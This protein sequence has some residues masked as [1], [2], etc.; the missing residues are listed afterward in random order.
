MCGSEEQLFKAKIEGTEMNVCSECSKFGE[1]ITI[2]K[3]EHKK[4][5]KEV[6]PAQVEK[7]PEVVE[8][9]VSDFAEKLRKKREELGL[10][11]ENFAKKLNQKKSIVHKMENGEIVPSIDLAKKIE[12]LLGVK[13]IEEYA[14]KDISFK[15]KGTSSEEL[16]IGDLIKVKT[17]KNE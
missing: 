15:G 10:D 3:E 6:K 8:T 17:R 13:L 16:T 9:I 2:V 12:K 5:K 11:Q 1:I 7:E 14:E 4:P